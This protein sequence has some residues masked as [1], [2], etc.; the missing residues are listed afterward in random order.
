MNKTWDLSKL[1]ADFG[2]VFQ[3]DIELLKELTK[4]YNEAVGKTSQDVVSYLENVFHVAEEIEILTYKLYSYPSLVQ[5]T[6]VNNQQSAK[7]LAVISD[8]LN[9]MVV[10]GVRFCRYVKKVNVAEV[11]KQSSFLSE[12]EFNLQT[13]KQEAL[14]LLSEKEEELYANL[15]P[16]ASGSWSDLQSLATA[17]LE[18]AYREQKLTLSEVRNLAYDQDPLVRKDAYYAELAA[19]KGVEN[20]V[21]LGLSNIKREV[22][23]ITKLTKFKSPLDH[24]LYVCHMSKKSLNALLGAI[25]DKKGIFAKYLKEKAKFLGYKGGLPF[26]EMFAPVGKVSKTYSYEEAS[27]LVCQAYASFSPKLGAFGRKAFDNSWIDVLPHPGKVGGAFCSNIPPL[28][29]SRVLTNFTGSLSDCLTLAHELGH[30]YHGEIIAQ[31]KP[32]NW[33]YPM[34]LAETASIFCETITN[35][36]LLSKIDSPEEKLH[37]LESQI[38]DATQVIVD[39]LSRYK[40]EQ[41]V[42]AL[43]N[44]PASAQELKDLMLKA[45]KESYLD[46]LDHDLLHPYMWLC[47]GHYYSAGFNF[48]N[49]PY[50]FGLLY[51]QGLYANYLTGK[52]EFVQKYD[53]MLYATTHKTAENVALEM[54]VDITDKKFWLSSLKQIENTINEVVKLFHELRKK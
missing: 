49:F 39:I 51:A 3:H 37:I 50:A 24:S 18:I 13:I 36:Y 44:A 25:E 15:K 2:S 40:F 30:A 12:Y 42:I 4:K 35:N 27:D 38:Q 29:E 17:N 20:F 6:D 19:Y 28:N 52:E 14:H 16:L 31:N 1:Y 8:I 46:G 53:K 41:S 33:D 26:Y 34:Q 32:L 54:G 7:A 47:K 43:G 9:T 22:N 5:A 11:V 21:A 10:A 23:I 48:Y 45:Q